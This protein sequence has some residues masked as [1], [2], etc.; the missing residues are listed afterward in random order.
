VY[1]AT[2][3]ETVRKIYPGVCRYTITGY[4]HRGS[5]ETEY[6]QCSWYENGNY[7]E[8][9][10]VTPADS[11]ELRFSIPRGAT[12]IS[13]HAQDANPTGYTSRL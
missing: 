5:D 11:S 2:D 4:N 7:Q 6:I 13:W 9:T 12:D 1:F 3:K 8:I 10:P